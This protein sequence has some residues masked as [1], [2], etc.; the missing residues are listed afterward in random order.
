MV[1]T[2]VVVG[3][4]LNLVVFHNLLSL[5]VLQNSAELEE[6]ENGRCSRFGGLE[7][8]LVLYHA[9]GRL[10]QLDHLDHLA[11][12]LCHHGRDLA[13]VL[14]LEV[15]HGRVLCLEEICRDR[16]DMNPPGAP[17]FYQQSLHIP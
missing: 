12:F 7:I 5:A 15:H 10:D 3:N 1:E 2:K 9:L 4:F 13:T 11:L 8:P 6:V 14:C 17:P 16:L